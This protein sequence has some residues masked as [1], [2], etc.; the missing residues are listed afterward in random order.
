MEFSKL[1]T[2]VIVTMLVS[3]KSNALKNNIAENEEDSIDNC[4]LVKLSTKSNG[5]FLNNVK[6]TIFLKNEVVYSQALNTEM[7]ENRFILKRD[8]QYTLQVSKDGYYTKWVC[9]NTALPEDLVLIEDFLYESKI[10]LELFKQDKSIHSFYVDLP[11]A[12]YSYNQQLN[13]FKY[14][15][16]YTNDME[17]TLREET[18]GKDILTVQV[19]PN[20]DNQVNQNSTLLQK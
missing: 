7:I 4:L 18:G 2:I 16:E 15:E 3:L 10:E 5:L 20:K 11:I 13:Q 14:I 19:V 17:K 6:I 8:N 1:A 12:I 9:I